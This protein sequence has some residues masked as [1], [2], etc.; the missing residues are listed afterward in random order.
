MKEE[1]EGESRELPDRCSLGKRCFIAKHRGERRE[2]RRRKAGK[3]KKERS[4]NLQRRRQ[5]NVYGVHTPPFFSALFKL[6]LL[7]RKEE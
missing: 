6:E 7:V 1:E 4:D 2:R 3:K 5:R